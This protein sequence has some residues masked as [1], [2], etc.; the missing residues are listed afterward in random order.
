MTATPLYHQRLH[1]PHGGEDEGSTV[2]SAGVDRETED[3]PHREHETVTTK[4]NGAQK[5]TT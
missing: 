3:V 2:A 1:A 5:S 4:S